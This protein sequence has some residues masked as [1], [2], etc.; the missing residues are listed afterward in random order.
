[1]SVMRQL[2]T[3][4]SDHSTQ[5]K[6]Q[7]A[8]SYHGQYGHIWRSY[9][10]AWV[11]SADATQAQASLGKMKITIISII[12]DKEIQQLHNDRSGCK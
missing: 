3:N 6:N 4:L 10:C 12:Y 9:V 5:A 2:T 1:M 8:R 7:L 11:L